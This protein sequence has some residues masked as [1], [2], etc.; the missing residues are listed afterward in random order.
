MGRCPACSA[1]NTLV[2]EIKGREDAGPGS[3]RNGLSAGAA[4]VPL[5]EASLVDEPRFP[6]AIR[7][8]DRVLGGG[9]VPGSLV[10]VG[11]DP[12]IGKSTLLL[13][14][15]Q[16]LAAGG[17]KILYVS[18]EES[19]QQVRLRAERLGVTSAEVYLATETDVTLIESFLD[20]VKP[21]AAVIDSIQTLFRPDIS[22]APGSVSQVRECAAQLLRLAKSRNIAVFLVGHVTKSGEI[23]GPRVLEH[24]VDTVLYFEGERHTSYRILRAV[25][26]RF[27]STHEVGIFEMRDRGLAEVT[28]PSELFLA[29]R[30][31][32]ASGSVVVPLLEGTRPL[33]VEIQ[34]LVGSANFMGNPRRLAT[35]LD[36]NRVSIILAVLEKR[37]GLALGSQDVYVNVA[38][39]VRVEEP[40]ADLGLAVAIASSLRNVAV[41]PRVVVLG[42]VGLAGEVRGVSRVDHRVA[43]AAKLGFTAG[44]VPRANLKGLDAPAGFKIIGVDEVGAALEYTT[45]R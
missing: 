21:S 28:N 8:F 1:W 25:K 3:E 5:S 12:G 17:H 27:G 26:N 9:V 29:E 10:L 6:T 43:E 2:E 44:I 16:G 33:L 14:V 30:P 4:P 38:G 20:K 45:A 23:A 19:V 18:G 34:A 7:E 40:G 36:Y 41:D 35:G 42:E 37:T 31:T 15:A 39:G 13:Q 32:G 24:V 22:A 11:G